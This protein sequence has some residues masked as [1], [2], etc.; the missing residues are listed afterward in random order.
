MTKKGIPRCHVDAEELASRREGIRCNLRRAGWAAWAALLMVLA[1][2]LAAA[3]QAELARGRAVGE[4]QARKSADRSANE[5]REELWRSQLLDA[6]FYRLNGGF[7]QRT[8]DLEI[9]ATAARYRPTVDLRNEAIAAMVLPDVGTNLW[10]RNEDNPARPLAFSANLAFFVPFNPTGRVAVCT[11]SNPIPLAEFIGSREPAW[12]A[13]FS[14][15]SRYVAIRFHDGEVRVW[16]WRAKQLILATASLPDGIGRQRFDFTPDSRELW[17]IGADSVI[18]RHALPDGKRLAQFTSM[19]AQTLSLDPSGRRLLTTKSNRLSAWDATTGASLGTW[20]APGDIW[21]AVWH[22][23]GREFVVGTYG[24]GVFVGETGRTNLD[25]LEASSP[26]NVPT[27][28]AFTPDGSLVLVGGWGNTFAVW[29]LASRKLALRSGEGALVQLSADGQ[30]VALCDEYRGYGVR[31]FLSPVGVRRLRVPANPFSQCLSVA[32]HPTGDHLVIGSHTGWS[33][34]DARRGELLLTRDGGAVQSIQFLR[35]GQ[36]FLTGGTAGPTFWPLHLD[37]EIPRVDEPVHLLPEKRGAN[38]RAALSPDNKSFAAVG[39]GGALLGRLD[40]TEPPRSLPGGVGDCYVAYS[41]DGRWIYTGAH[42]GGTVRIHSA[43]TGLVVTNLAVGTGVAW[44]VPGGQELVTIGPGELSF[45]EIGSWQ[46]V[47]RLPIRNANDCQGFGGFWPDGS[48]ALANGQDGMLRLWDV[49]L[50]REIACLRLVEG[51]ALWSGE[52]DSTGQFMAA[53]SSHSFLRV[54]DFP[55]L[56]RELGRLGLDWP[57]GPSDHHFTSDLTT[58]RE[59]ISPPPLA[60]VPSVTNHA[61]RPVLWLIFGGMALAIAF[62]V[63][64]LAYQ[65]NLFLAYSELDVIAAQQVR[66]LQT[67]Q[68]ALLHREKMQALG[69]MAA[70][71]A[72]DFN[73][74]LS[75]IRLSNEL[76]EEQVQPE[77]MMR[78]NFQSIQQAVQRGRGIVNSMLGYAREDGIPHRV[79]PGT[80]ISD[81][82]AMLGKTFLSGLVLQIEVDP[83]TPPVLARKG[84]V[85]QMLLNLIVNAAEAMNGRG[86]LRLTVREVRE[87]GP[88]VLPAGAAGPQVELGVTDSGPGIAPEVLARIFDPFVTTKTKGAHAGTGLG[89]SML[90]TMAREDGIGVAV[91]SAPGQGATFRLLLPVESSSPPGTT[92]PLTN[93]DR[94]GQTGGQHD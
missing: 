7:G 55:A 52:F 69:T 19:T 2:A 26:G 54:W 25:L 72:H 40:Q 34:W 84:R 3:W 70:G 90:Y 33:L 77:G 48:C 35:S 64:M 29:D 85:E 41:P 11:T 27:A 87:P 73:N 76:I 74:L 67:T 21:C 53:T 93:A 66:E 86:T 62:G 50:A 92:R 61:A 8:R 18:Q 44:F 46:C 14:S 9:I 57:S 43:L 1:L 31:R 13:R 91:T 83:A 49:K 36:G 80:F 45:W 78:E 88:C 56:R 32:W 24:A 23:H 37:S 71:I 65:R 51:S 28:V 20:L 30:F 6:K 81:A 89:L 47:R 68:T 63:A 39:S 15:D 22:P 94:L 58:T 79:A 16:D 10:W 38:E 17:L 59:S 4:H 82:V 42:N 12:S 5:A 75:V 60:E